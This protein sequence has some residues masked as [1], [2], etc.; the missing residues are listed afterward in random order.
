MR[1]VGD[2]ESV[3]PRTITTFELP[4]G[5]PMGTLWRA[6]SDRGIW[7]VWWES[8]QSVLLDAVID[9]QSYLVRCSTTDGECERVFDLGPYTYPPSD[10]GVLYDPGWQSAWAFARSPITD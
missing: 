9:G 3:E 2:I 8:D 5:I 4:E 6:Y 1:P 10:Q 7:G